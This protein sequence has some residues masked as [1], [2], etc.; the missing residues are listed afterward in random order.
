MRRHGLQVVAEEL[1]RCMPTSST[2]QGPDYC[3]AVGI[4]PCKSPGAQHSI[5]L[6]AGASTAIL[7]KGT[8]LTEIP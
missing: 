7:S 6:Q 3:A 1:D 2:T 4:R 8:A 5:T